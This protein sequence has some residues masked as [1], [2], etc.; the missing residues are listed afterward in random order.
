[1][2]SPEELR[3]KLSKSQFFKDIQSKSKTDIL[4]CNGGIL[5]GVSDELETV[6]SL[7][8]NNRQTLSTICSIPLHGITSMSFSE[9]GSLLMWSSTG[10]SLIPFPVR[11]GS[12]PVTIQERLGAE[13]ILNVKWF[14]QKI[15]VLKS[16]NEVLIYEDPKRRPV[17]MPNLTVRDKLTDVIGLA[18]QEFMTVSSNGFVRINE[19]IICNVELEGDIR[20]QQIQEDIFVA[21]TPQMAVHFLLIENEVIVVEKVEIAVSDSDDD[22]IQILVDRS[23]DTRY[24]IFSRTGLNCVSLNWVD[25]MRDSGKISESNA[26]TIEVLITHANEKG[27]TINGTALCLDRAPNSVSFDGP[28]CCSAMSNGTAFFIPLLSLPSVLC[29]A[30]SDSTRKPPKIPENIIEKLKSMLSK[31]PT[32]LLPANG[33]SLS[34]QEQIKIVAKVIAEMKTEHLARGKATREAINEHLEVLNRDYKEQSQS[35][36]NIE[37]VKKDLR[38]SAERLGDKV[39]SVIE[40]QRQIEERLINVMVQLGQG[41]M[42]EAEKNAAKELRETE[43][44]LQVHK[45]TISRLKRMSAKLPPAEEKKRKPIASGSL[46][47]RPLTDTSEKISDLVREI[48]SLKL[49]LS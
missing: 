20:L 33:A 5:F 7:S 23:C 3:K 19:D 49:E 8:L 45:Q 44:Q 32:Y 22:Q 36:S 39:E 16:N 18:E 40:K 2:T 6:V 30:K 1:M 31:P 48:K 42:T 38:S 21:A 25:D 27:A 43:R 15:V 46:L 37:S 14:R 17:I 35:L 29:V 47:M 41:R 9:S 4:V 24:F 13:Y 10:V 34:T 26:S 11:P 12:T 28:T